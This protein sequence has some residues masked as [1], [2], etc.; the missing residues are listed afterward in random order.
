MSYL[1]RVAESEGCSIFLGEV[2]GAHGTC[3]NKTCTC[4]NGWFSSRDLYSS[5]SSPPCVGNLVSLQ[6][7][8]IISTIIHILALFITIR[9]LKKL[10]H[11]KRVALFLLQITAFT[12]VSILKPGQ[13]ETAFFGFDPILTILLSLGIVLSF[14]AFSIYYGRFLA[15]LRN[16]DFIRESGQTIVSIKYGIMI[17]RVVPRLSIL[18]CIPSVSTS[19]FK[20]S[21]EFQGK[22]FSIFLWGY[23]VL[24]SLFMCL[25]FVFIR[26]VV[27][28]A[29]SLLASYSTNNGETAETKRMEK[30]LFRLN[31]ARLLYTSMFFV[32][33]TEIF[34]AVISVEYTLYQYTLPFAMCFSAF[35]VSYKINS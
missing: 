15:Y 5:K 17:F 1:K 28:D 29:E 30:A 14:Y 8:Y 35:A 32:L 16:L 7:M 24:Y 2:C 34:I 18:F 4:E 19:L 12:L 21:K 27:E 26:Q 11:L 31:N 3:I 9:R 20:L 23:L 10:K 33:T 13:L 6:V 22:S 25:H